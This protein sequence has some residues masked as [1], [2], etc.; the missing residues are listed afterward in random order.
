M[1]TPFDFIDAGADDHDPVNGITQGDIRRWND[2]WTNQIFVVSRCRS[3][4]RLLPI[5]CSGCQKD[6]ES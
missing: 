6:W 5:E 3:C 4:K 1:K 2:E